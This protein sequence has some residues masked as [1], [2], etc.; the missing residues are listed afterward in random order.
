MAPKRQ[1]APT[2]PIERTNS[3][4]DQDFISDYLQTSIS[5]SALL[6]PSSSPAPKP[7]T[8]K[9]THP[10]TNNQY[11]ISLVRSDKLSK[12]E[13]QACFD[14]VKETS[15]DDYQ[16]S[17]DKWQPRKKMEEMKSPG[18]R[19]V[20]VQDNKSENGGSIRAF[21]SLMPTYEEGQPVVYCYEIHLKPELQGS[22][23]GSLLMGFHV[24]VATN[25]PPITKVMLTCFL[26]NERAL[27]F[28]KR[29]GFETDDISPG[30]RK[31]PP[32]AEDNPSD[33]EKPSEDKPSEDQPSEAQSSE[34]QSSEDKPSERKRLKAE[35]SEDHSLTDKQNEDGKSNP[36]PSQ[37]EKP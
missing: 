35:T 16:N 8:T 17:K 7:W 2:S 21:T 33:E 13:L 29:H 19:Y 22:G 25:L 11:T 23:L 31:F 10:K 37:D 36:K 12:E 9:W 24:I 28:Y 14:L 26:S 32:L 15:Y 27:G 6:P 1:R 5:S 30:P 4:T 20:L 18:L 34:A 3:K